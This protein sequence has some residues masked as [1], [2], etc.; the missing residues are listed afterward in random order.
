MTRLLD[1]CAVPLPA[2]TVARAVGALRAG[3]VVAIPTDTVYGLAADP[4]VPGA[5]SALFALKGRPPEVALPVLVASVEQALAVAGPDVAQPA[6]ALVERWWPGGLTVV[7]PRREGLGWELGGSDQSTVGLRL[8]A[9][10][11]PV[12]LAGALGPLAVSSAN[13]HG[14]PTPATAPEV[15]EELGPGLALALDGGPCRGAA[16]TVVSCIEGTVRVLREGAV[17]GARILAG[18]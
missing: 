15:I 7:V 4:R 11:V 17:P 10:P 9:H 1:A 6:L 8:P 3:E 16:S 13:R 2:P 18:P 5:T 14:R 12:A